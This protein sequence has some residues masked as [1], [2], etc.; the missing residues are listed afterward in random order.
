[1]TFYDDALARIPTQREKILAALQTAG[2]EGVTNKELSRI[3]LQ[4]SARIHELLRKGYII[5]IEKT[6]DGSG[7]LKYILRKDTGK[8]RYFETAEE[9]LLNR[10]DYEFGSVNSLELKM[11][12]SECQSHIVRRANYYKEGLQ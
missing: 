10:I 12:L 9:E 2:A 8:E 4:Y 1:M 5:D 7:L 6:E 11:L 3:S